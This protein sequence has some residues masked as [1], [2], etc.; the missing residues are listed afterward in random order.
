MSDKPEALRLA[1]ALE[2]QF[3]VGTA[4]DY[5]D[6]ESA[7]ELRRQHVEIE[8]LN[9]A[10]KWEQDRSERI[11]THG[12]G[13]HTWGHRHYECLLRQYKSLLEALEE[14]CACPQWVDEATVPKAGIETAPQQVVVNL[15]VALVRLR[16]A[17]AAI[18]KATGENT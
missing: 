6:G 12:Q 15:S 9:A 1:D 3:P 11:C 5:L 8:R 18:A 4:Q 14:L 2:Q 7:K 13:C 16:K 17:R 10:L